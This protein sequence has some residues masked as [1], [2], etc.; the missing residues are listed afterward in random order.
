MGRDLIIEIC[1]YLISI[2]IALYS[3]ITDIKYHIVKNKVLLIGLALSIPLIAIYYIGYYP[4]FFTKYIVNV[5]ACIIISF[6]LY[7]LRIWGG[8]DSKL[9]ILIAI[10]TPARLYYFNRSNLPML[11]FPIFVFSIGYIYL[12]IESIVYGIREKKMIKLPS[13]ETI[14]KFVKSYLFL[15]IYMLLISEIIRLL[16]YD[17]YINNVLF[18]W[19]ISSMLSIALYKYEIFKNKYVFLIAICLD[20]LL[21]S[22]NYSFKPIPY[23]IIF[24]LFVLKNYMMTYN[25]RKIEINNLKE[26]DVLSA[27]STL[28]FQNSTIENLPVNISENLSARLTKDNINAINKWMRYHPETKEVITVAKIPFVLFILLGYIYFIVIEVMR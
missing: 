8:G 18:F 19:I 16:F 20:I 1:L 4:E 11:E 2:S 9:F 5:L 3:T 26:G 25:Y 13:K 10:C 17:F 15:S 27:G 6:A 23:I 22:R 14:V 24:V 28:L 21:K 12:L 7:Y